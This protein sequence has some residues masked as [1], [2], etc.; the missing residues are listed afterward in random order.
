MIEWL[1]TESMPMAKPQYWRRIY[2]GSDKLLYDAI[3][4]RLRPLFWVFSHHPDHISVSSAQFVTGSLQDVSVRH[5]TY[6]QYEI[7][8]RT[9]RGTSTC[10]LRTYRAHVIL[11]PSRN[12][13]RT[14]L[15][16][17]YHR[18]LRLPDAANASWRANELIVTRSRAASA[19]C[20]EM[21]WG[22]ERLRDMKGWRTPSCRRRPK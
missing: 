18:R 4:S 9:S 5:A 10:R 19:R 12:W 8:D 16:G 15:D 17:H 6:W 22:R 11:F 20:F 1:P 21:R 14:K 7:F 3:C 2:C 13:H